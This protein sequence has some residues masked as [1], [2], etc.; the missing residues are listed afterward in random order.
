MKQ[1]VYFREQAF[2]YVILL[3]YVLLYVFFH[4]HTFIRVSLRYYSA[5]VHRDLESTGLS[6]QVNL[7]KGEADI[8]AQIDQTHGAT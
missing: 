4:I 6:V 3:H 5:K 1:K 8:R 2:Y 7:I